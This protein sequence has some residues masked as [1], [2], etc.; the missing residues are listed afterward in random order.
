ML[1]R[2]RTPFVLTS[3][4]AYVINGGDKASARFHYFVDLCAQ[5]FNIV[6]KEGNVILNLF[7]LVRKHFLIIKQVVKAYILLNEVIIE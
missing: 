7:G 1:Y 2:D 6:R 5:A 3:D 4:M